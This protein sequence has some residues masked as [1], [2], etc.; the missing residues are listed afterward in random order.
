MRGLLVRAGCKKIR[1][2]GKACHKTAWKAW[3]RQQCLGIQ[4]DRA[5]NAA[6]KPQVTNVVSL[7][8]LA[9]ESK[10]ML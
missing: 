1:F 8:H 4:A 10:A 9:F 3:H 6:P 7:H 2:C 5:Q